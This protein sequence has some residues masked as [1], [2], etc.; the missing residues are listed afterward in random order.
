VK[1]DPESEAP[2]RLRHAKCA[3]V[4]FETRDRDMDRDNDREK[5]MEGLGGQWPTI[6][7]GTHLVS[8]W[9]SD[10]GA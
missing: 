9:G 10:N 5:E 6:N 7:N 2:M 3:L 1:D 8:S 4:L